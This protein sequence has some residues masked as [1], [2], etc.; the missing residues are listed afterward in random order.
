MADGKSY[1]FD[2]F[3]KVVKKNRGIVVALAVAM[4]L[5][6]AYTNCSKATFEATN[7]LRLGS[8][9]TSG[10]I[11]INNGDE[12]TTLSNVTLAVTHATADR[13]YLTNDPTCQ[14]GG[15]W[16]NLASSKPWDLGS[17]NA[18]SEVYVKFSDD[19]ALASD[20]LSDSI[21]H[22]DIAPTLTVVTP[23][24]QFTNAADVRAT[25]AATDS[26]SGVGR[27]AC[28]GTG[29]FEECSPAAL[30]VKSPAE[31]SHSYNAVAI[32]RAGNRSISRT[33]SFLVDRTVPTVTTN[34]LPSSVNNSPVSEFRFSGDDTLS[35]VDH[36][37]CRVGA[38]P[39][40]A[41]VPFKNCASGMTETLVAG[42]QKFEVRSVDRAT[43]ISAVAAHSWTID[44]GAPTVRITKM[45]GPI[46]NS[47][48]ATFEFVGD[49]D[50]G[51]LA[52]YSCSLNGGPR[53]SCAS[54][55][56]T[57]AGPPEGSY[58][59][60]VV[61]TDSAG[62]TSA[63]ASYTWIVDTTRPTLTIKSKPALITKSVSA[64][65][66]LDA[67]DANGIDSIECQID[68]GG[69]RPCTT[70]VNY[71]TL[72]D[73]LRKF[74]ARAKDRAGNVSDVATYSWKID[75]SKPTVKIS[76]GPAAWIKIRAT[77]LT[78]AAADVN[79]ATGLPAP[80]IECKMNDAAFASCM[81]PMSYSALNQGNFT[82]TVRATDAAGNM[83]DEDKYQ[84]GVD[85]TPPA[86]NF[87]TQP[88]STIYRNQISNIAFTATDSPSGIQTVLCGLNG[89]LATC[90]PTSS[91]QFLNLPVGNHKFK[92]QATDKAGNETV[93]EVAWQISDKTR[94][95]IQLVDVKNN[96]KLDVLVVIDNSGSMAN[97]HKNM[98][99]RFGTF[100]DKLDGVDWQIGIVTTDVS[101]DSIKR[102]GRLVE[103]KDVGAAATGKYVITS[104]M[105]KETA[106]AWF[107]ATIQMPTDGSGNEQGIAA[108][109]RALQR[110]Q[111]T[112]DAISAFNSPLIRSDSALAV[113]VVTDADETNPQGTQVQNKPETLINYV[114]TT[115]PSKAFSYHSIVVP[116]MDTV[117]KAADGNE[118]YGLSYISISSLTG[119]ITG[120]VCATD[121]G[122]QLSDIGKSTQELIKTVSLNCAP[123]DVD[124][125]GLPEMAIVT[126]NGS[127]APP[128]TIEGGTLLK[129][130]TPLP[131]GQTK[132]TYNCVIPL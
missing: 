108:T 45:P 69:Y 31:G 80:T 76:A 25:L 38:A 9:N 27:A 121:Y 39:T 15:T 103:F 74:D 129:F 63:P 113:L 119:G 4:V 112:G 67:N 54:P 61:G 42:P 98:A 87:G 43:N 30:V 1:H 50:S 102:D 83:S 77:S 14:T 65:F 71:P 8:L 52:S 101:K 68:G 82:F 99:M 10:A 79:V 109:L 95:E 59:F 12:F 17:L 44:L 94:E 58:T 51:A 91:T 73:G 46:T 106:K 37:E 64:D 18:N 105:G 120:T 70:T 123:V 6:V 24:P 132:F 122:A 75:T 117:C 93:S 36:F 85:L 16:E 107:A 128:Y 26:G 23:P 5:Q 66:V 72:T 49:D 13:M 35:G 48:Q 86:V 7:E 33:V 11:V 88:L 126:P 2:H 97:E 125:D 130:A 100:I 40:F 89:V 96:T 29:A 20:C 57:V 114:K 90:T 47:T 22:D 78:F 110:S 127:P 56:N 116:N 118:A 111:Q 60:S 3:L 81:S 34:L 19:G 104:A 92:V 115:F 53:A 41:S 84:F 62:N 32:D 131:V 124:G 55:F 21:V 28:T